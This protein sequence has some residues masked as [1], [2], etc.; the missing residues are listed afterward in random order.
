MHYGVGTLNLFETLLE[1]EVGFI[2]RR[3]LRKQA[4]LPP[5]DFLKDGAGDTRDHLDTAFEAVQ[6]RG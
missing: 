2:A 3:L 4:I 1:N 5:E 6:V